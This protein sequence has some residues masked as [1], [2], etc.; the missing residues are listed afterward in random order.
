MQP[1]Q[2]PRPLPLSTQNPAQPPKLAYEFERSEFNTTAEPYEIFQTTTDEP[3]PRNWNVNGI[4]IGE[5]LRRALEVCEAAFDDIV[6]KSADGV[7]VVNPGG[8][9]C[10]A[11]AAAESMLG[12]STG[13]LLG[14]P[15]VMPVG[16]GETFE[17]KLPSTDQS[18]HF[19]EIRVVATNWQG[20]P[21][22]LATLRDVTQR[23]RA[24]RRRDEFLA[25][26]S[27][28]L[29][30][31]LAAITS[32]ASVL[33]R[34]NLDED[35]FAKARGVIER[36]C[37]QM[38][39][40]LADLLDV[41]RATRAKIELRK[42]CLDLVDVI[43]EAVDAVRGEAEAVGQTVS[44]VSSEDMLP[45]DGDAVRLHQVFV[46]LLS[47]ASKFSGANSPIRV[48]IGI[49][50]EQAVVR[51]RDQ[52]IG[53]TPEAL[54]AVFQPFLQLDSSLDR[55][56]E[57][58]GL[59]LAIADSLIKLHGGTV[60]AASE[61]LG[62]GSEF[63]VRLPLSQSRPESAPTSTDAATETALRVVIV[64][65]NADVGEMLK[66]L[67]ECAG[68]HVEV[69]ADGLSGAELI[70]RTLPDVALVDIG[71][72]ALNGYQLAQRIRS[73]A[74]HREVFLAALTGYGQPADQEKALSSGFD[75]HIAKPV[76]I[77]HLRKL[78]ASRR[79]LRADAATA[80]VEQI[81]A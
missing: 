26:L 11:N 72:P 75:T 41:S 63:C 45:V 50:N 23:N 13:E 35:A 59:G 29:R 15:F 80:E 5:S 30:N 10:F 54:E 74:A 60:R 55:P 53:M 3:F 18:C 65:D 17:M 57:G 51:V 34:P 31:P 21:A 6:D 37:A 25:M 14:E 47:N 64:E 56:G 43:I 8:T 58:L 7:V 52:G 1:Q 79:R 2:P 46:N 12:R 22:L 24:L 4:N 39:R 68:H 49:E 32:A 44:L 77:E 78:L 73:D 66:T 38:T 40:L 67:L 19:A 27:H 16:P 70:E 61:G 42:E 62:K 69:A 20:A 76:S 9:I 81:S 71:L 48:M 33:A 28:E 36:Q